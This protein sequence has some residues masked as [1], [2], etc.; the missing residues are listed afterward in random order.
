MGLCTKNGIEI[1]GLKPPTDNDDHHHDI[2]D[3][4]E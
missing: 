2:H 1:E 3:D 4:E